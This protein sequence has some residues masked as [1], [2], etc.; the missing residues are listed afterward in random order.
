MPRNDPLSTYLADEGYK[1]DPNGLLTMNAD[2]TKEL[3]DDAIQ[4]DSAG[5]ETPLRV[6]RATR[7]RFRV[8]RD[9]I[10]YKKNQRQ[11]PTIPFGFNQIIALKADDF[12]DF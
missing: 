3:L 7:S 5:I 2:E 6:D 8:M 11:D 1:R 12:N 10:Q 9:F 4:K